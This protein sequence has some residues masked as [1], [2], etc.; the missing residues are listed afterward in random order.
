MNIDDPKL[1]A[2]AL[3]ELPEQERQAIEAQ[4]RDDPAARAFVEETAAFSQLL[5]REFHAETPATEL[6]TEQRSAVLN[7]ARSGGKIIWFTPRRI[8][9]AAGIAINA[10][11]L[12][13]AFVLPWI[14]TPTIPDDFTGGGIEVITPTI[15]ASTL[16]PPPPSSEMNTTSPTAV[17]A[18]R[19]DNNEAVAFVPPQIQ[20]VNKQAGDRQ[21]NAITA[22]AAPLTVQAAT[23]AS[24]SGKTE[25]VVFKQKSPN[26]AGTP[27]STS[28]LSKEQIQKIGAF[29]SGWSKK[30]PGGI[31]SS[32]RGRVLA[33]ATADSRGELYTSVDELTFK[34]S[35]QTLRRNSA[36]G[37][38][39]S[40]AALDE[41][42]FLDVAQNP[43]STFSIDV[44]TASYA[45]V[46]RFLQSGQR[47]PPGAVRIEE[48]INYFPYNYP[49]PKGDAPFSVNLETAQCPWQPEHRLVRIGL[50][51]R[52]IANA[53]RPASNLV[54]LLD[55]SGSMDEENKLPLLKKSMRLL[56]EKLGENDKIAIV[57]YAGS[58]GIALPPTRGDQKERIFQA[59]DS[60]KAGGST[61][62]A[63]GIQL[64]YKTATKSFIPEGTNRV[65]LATDGDFNVGI[66]SE[67]ELVKLI[68]EQRKSGVFLSV[69]G[70]GEGNLKDS[71]MKKLSSH[72]NGNYAYID[73]LRE[74]RKVLVESMGGTLITIAKD[75]KIQVEF[76]PRKVGAY[77]LVGYESRMLAKE[78][79]NNDKKDAGEIGAGHTVTALYEITPAASKAGG[80]VDPLKYQPEKS[81]TPS[82]VTAAPVS[83]ELLTVKLRYKSPNGETSKLIEQPATDSESTIQQCSPDFMFAASVAEFGMLL[84]GSNQA[85]S[86]TWASA[87][88]L[89]TESKGRDEGGYRAEFLQLLERA[90]SMQGDR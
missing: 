68:E 52:E 74:G 31:G 44:D 3:G 23:L 11:V 80:A 69:L 33:K 88:D 89:A 58:T 64:A 20:P 35:E 43:L 45:N 70:F 55:V 79:F 4:L 25:A 38:T 62:G 84:R 14:K 13:V 40:Y 82:P 60:L 47:P 50:K 41:N 16:P 22:P 90:K 78:D 85:G 54:F 10:A 42:P 73:S 61:N 37:N 66:S 28:S 59:L 27:V 32:S 7:E 2:Y 12:A 17:E 15:S 21:A 29:T 56:V 77:R 5:S 9:W 63:G 67:S 36:P 39:E 65:I 75:V 24:S 51:G 87:H 57:V 72:G 34:D 53:E 49:Q 86:A 6:D 1:T 30:G 76:N 46:R 26:A 81:A 48:L 71:M 83:N 19:T 8:A 18:I